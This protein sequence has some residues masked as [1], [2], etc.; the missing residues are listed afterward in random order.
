[1]HKTTDQRSLWQI[2]GAENANT[3]EAV[4]DSATI[5]NSSRVGWTDLYHQ[6]QQQQQQ[7]Q[8]HFSLLTYF[9]C[10]TKRL[11]ELLHM[12]LSAVVS[13]QG[14]SLRSWVDVVVV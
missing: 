8:K 4:V 7:Q 6:Q 3:V 13:R 5:K 10:K 2:S 12:K 14:S 9:S 1:V 11:S